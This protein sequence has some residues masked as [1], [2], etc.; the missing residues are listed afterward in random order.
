MK[1]TRKV[2]ERERDEDAG[3]GK[4]TGKKERKRKETRRG[5]FLS[6]VPPRA[7]NNRQLS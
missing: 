7:I 6:P 3:K 5:P 4:N 1:T 2:V